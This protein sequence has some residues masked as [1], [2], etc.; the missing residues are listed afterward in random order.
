MFDSSAPKPLAERL[1]PTR[2]DE[3]VGQDHLLR[4]DGPIGRMLAARRLS[5]MIL[6][7]P[8]GVGKT[9]IALLLAEQA[10]LEFARLSAVMSGVAELRKAMET[11]QAL[12]RSGR[13]TALFL[14]EIH[15]WN[16]AQQDGLLPYVEDGTITLI[17]ATTEN[18]SFEL[19][20]ALLSRCQVFVLRRFDAEACGKLMARAE[21]QVGRPLPVTA[22]AREALVGMADGDGRYLLN[23]CDELFALDPPAPL[24]LAGLQ[25]AL[26]KRAP[27][28]DKATDGH[29]GLFSALQK[30]IRGSDVQASLYWLARMLKAGEPPKG[31]FRRLAVMATEEIGLADPNAVQHTMACAQS[32]ERS[33]EP[34][35]LPALGQCVAYLATAVKSNAV[36]TAFYEAMDLAGRTGSIPPPRHLINAPTA[37]MKAMGFKDGYRYDHDFEHAFSGQEFFPEGLDGAARPNLY[38]PNERG[39]EREILKRMQFWDGLRDR[40]KG[41]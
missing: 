9:T 17:G 34:E 36:Y 33:G 2:L 15:R 41:R 28:Y 6:W 37:M 21:A 38:R 14:D 1:R 29:Y 26:Q 39:N 24:D 4:P 23:L 40:L 8:P 10:G 35:G 19:N 13:G 27:V 31:I 25:E 32:F 5:S 12:R 18:P 16:K 20:A 3:V 7:G 22:E 11:A 30:S